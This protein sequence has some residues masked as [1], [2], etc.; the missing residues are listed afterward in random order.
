MLILVTLAN[1]LCNLVFIILY[2]FL[3]F[4]IVPVWNQNR[5]FSILI[6]IRLES[7]KFTLN[8]TRTA[9]IQVIINFASKL[10]HTF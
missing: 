6:Y 4:L 2:F 7:A 5:P 8:L 3:M 10:I 9:Q 1:M